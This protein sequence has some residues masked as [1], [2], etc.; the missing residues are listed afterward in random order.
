MGPEQIWLIAIG[1]FS[2]FLCNVLYMAGGTGFDG[3]GYKWLRRFLGSSILGITANAIAMYMHV[4][5]WQ[6]LLMIPALIIGFSL[7]YGGDTTAEKV[8]KR[9]ICALG[10]LSACAIGYWATGFTAAGL[11]VL[12]MSGIVGATSIYMGV[13]NPF[14]NAP[15]EQFLICQV[16]T[17]FVPFWAFVK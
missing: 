15:L 11:G 8:F 6:Y 7:G 9:T 1:G 13:A 2:A 3:K 16:L 12:I 17:L 14:N 10:I 5:V 4:W